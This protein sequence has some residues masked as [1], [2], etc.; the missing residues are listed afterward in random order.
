MSNGTFKIRVTGRATA[1]RPTKRSIVVT[2]RREGFL[3]FVYFTVYENIDPQAA[4]ERHGPRGRAAQ[5]RRPLPERSRP[6]G[7]RV[8]E[9]QFPT[10]D[11]INGPLHTNDE[12]LSDLRHRRSSAAR[13]T[14]TAPRRDRH[15]RGLGPRARP[16]APQRRLRRHADRS[17]RR[18][19]SSRP[20]SSSWTCRRTNQELVRRGRQRR[21]RLLR[22]DDHAPQEHGDGRHQ[23]HRE[24]N[25]DDDAQRARGPATASSTSRTTARARARSRPTPTT[26]SR[27]RAATSTSAATIPSRS[28]SPPPTT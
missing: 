11:A 13:R 8:I 10:G 4:D 14:R 18:R 12:N 7:L 28:R 27:A 9:I 21:P 15:D 25:G 23:L 24:R 19:R 20:R 26:T 3:K 5:L 2:F 17:S 16:P 22:Q 6:R 1:D